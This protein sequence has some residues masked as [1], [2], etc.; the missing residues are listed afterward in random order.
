M[1]KVD[2]KKPKTVNPIISFRNFLLLGLFNLFLTKIFLTYETSLTS[3]F[4]SLVWYSIL[5]GILFF[6]DELVFSRIHFIYLRYISIYVLG[7]IIGVILV[8]ALVSSEVAI[9]L[10]GQVVI[11][12]MGGGIALFPKAILEN[13]IHDD[14]KHAFL[15]KIVVLYAC[16]IFFSIL[17]FFMFQTKTVGQLLIMTF[18]VALGIILWHH[19]SKLKKTPHLHNK[20]TK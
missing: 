17:L 15:E 6:I 14:L 11:F 7:G 3:Y 5:L 12:F 18:Y 13:D 16:L 8:N 4:L 9:N 10:L 20:E 1:E 2:K 19:V